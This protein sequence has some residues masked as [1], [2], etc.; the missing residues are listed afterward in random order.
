MTRRSGGLSWLNFP[1]DVLANVV[2]EG[3]ERVKREESDGKKT[4]INKY[5]NI[6]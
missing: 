4:N 3:K 5:N 1:I 6:I 2:M